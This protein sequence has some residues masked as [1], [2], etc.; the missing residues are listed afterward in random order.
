MPKQ[1]KIDKVS[2][3]RAR[4]EGSSALF[5][6]DFRGLTV[7]DV[8]ELRAALRGAGS[9]FAVVKNTLMKLAADEVGATGMRGILEGP[10][11]VAFVD[12]DPIA[13]AKSLTEA[14]RRFRTLELK[15]AYMEG[16]VLSAAEAASL[17]TIEPRE[18]LLAKFAGAAKMQMSR[19]AYMFVA[20]QS[21]FFGLLEAYREKLP[22]PE[23]V[24]EVEEAEELEELEEV[25]APV[26][27]T[28]APETAEPDGGN[29]GTEVEETAPD[30]GLPDEALEEEAPTTEETTEPDTEAETGSETD[31]E[32]Q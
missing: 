17:A 19:A 27:E 25:D 18:V 15:G 8:G 32:E 5:L 29:R 1:Q 24:E 9:S 31:G 4:M 21:R 20:L 7:G 16:R 2:E 12:G 3:L 22:A 13:A 11:A 14:G 28:A 30:A 6:T 26:A 23:Q 10:T